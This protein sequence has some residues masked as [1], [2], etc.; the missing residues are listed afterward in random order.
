MPLLM[1][2]RRWW[3]VL[4]FAV[5]C[6]PTIGF[7][8]PDLPAPLRTVVAP[9][10]RWWE[11]AAK[12]LDP[13]INN[14]FGF[15]GAV[16]AAHATYGR[17]IGAPNDKVLKGEL[18]ALFLKE[19]NAVEQSLGE[20]V[21]P[22]AVDGVAAAA[23]RLRQ[24]VEADGG[25]FV[26]VVPPNAHTVNFELLPAYA[27]RL[28]RAP[29]EYDL[30]AARMAEQKIPFVDLRPLMV[31]A[32]ADGPV[33]RRNDTH[34][35]ARG[36]LI[37]F[38]AAMAAA[39]RPD[40]QVSPADALGPPAETFGGDLVRMAGMT[41]SE[42]PDIEFPRR[43]PMAPP[44]NLTP[45]DGVMAPVPDSDPFKPQ[46]F[47]TGRAGP[48]IMVIGDSFTQGLWSGLL[49]SRASAFAWMHHRYCRFDMGAVER[50]RPD[51]L[52]YAPTERSLPCRG[53]K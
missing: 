6:L 42:Q 53:A 20:L 34:W 18:G 33:Y 46:A 52:I 7:L 24:A 38:N 8:V 40:L 43:G 13:Y 11:H 3:A 2:F 17:W 5:L 22:G 50:F 12:R 45:L 26:M 41:R 27:R 21:R 30:V 9:E 47:A 16:L 32:K 48:R 51:I 23:A 19:D 4:I 37:G 31:Q 25:R 39:G 14:A 36:A 10:A 35:N 15:R 49:A 28:K 1:S 44:Q 29:T